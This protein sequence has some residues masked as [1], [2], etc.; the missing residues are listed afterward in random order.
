[1]ST[2]LT[3]DDD[4]DEFCCLTWR[5]FLSPEFGTKLQRE[6]PL[7]SDVPK[8][9]YNTVWDRSKEAFVPKTS[10][11]R[12]VV[13]IQYRLVTDRRTDRQTNAGRQHIHTVIET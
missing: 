10:S 6:V 2:I 4:Y 3:V 7:F 12:P 8:F 5:N 1:M 11:I 13:S 9:P